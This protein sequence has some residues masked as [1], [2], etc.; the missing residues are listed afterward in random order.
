MSAGG[1]RSAPP[2]GDRVVVE[3]G[4]NENQ[5][6]RANPHVPYTAEELAAEA[7][8]CFD[9][10]ASVVHYH[11]R[12]PVTGEPRLSDPALHVA[13]QRAITR[14]APVL[15]YPS[16]GGEVRVLDYYDIGLP[17]PERYRHI[18]AIA[19]AGVRLEIAPVDLGALDANARWDPA[20]RSLVP[21]T[22]LLLNTGEDQRWMLNFCRRRR[23]RPHFTV[24]ELSHVEN[25]G[26]LIDWGLAGEPPHVVK[27]FLAGPAATPATLLFLRDRLLERLGQA[28]SAWLPLVYGTDQLPLCTLA[29]SLG[30]HVRVGIGDYAYPERG[31][32]TNAAL[33]EAAVEVCRALGREPAGPAEAHAAMGIENRTEAP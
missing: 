12:D 27:L 4:L 6:R 3:V 32:P 19:A 16:Y 13:A 22:G 7:R 10:G 14:A 33:V 9:A 30:G 20:T 1:A 25:L 15:A 23:L 2:T 17:A 28:A 18:E 8:R 29:A 26:R 21:S 31:A 5:D 11:G 24:F